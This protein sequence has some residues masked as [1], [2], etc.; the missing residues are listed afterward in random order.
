[1]AV[2]QRSSRSRSAER[3]FRGYRL[4]LLYTLWRCLTGPSDGAIRLEGFEDL[5]VLG[6]D[7]VIVEAVQVKAYNTPLVLSD[8][9]DEQTGPT[10]LRDRIAAVRASS[11]DARIKITSY[12]GFGPELAAFDKG[13]AKARRRV[14]AKVRLGTG[15]ELA[16]VI[17]LEECDENTIAASV[18]EQVATGIAGADVTTSTELMLY[19]LFQRAEARATITRAL[20]LERLEQVGRFVS[21]RAAHAAEW[22]TSIRPLTRGLEHASL[23]AL[24][25]QFDNGVNV[26]FEHVVAG[27]DVLRP[28]K[29][30]AVVDG[31]K[32]GSVV[33]VHGASG[34]GK[35]CL[36]YRFMHDHV[37]DAL[38]YEIRRVA[39]LPQAQR[40][41]L[42]LSEHARQC[43]TPVYVYVDVQPGDAQWSTLVEE[44]AVVP[45]LR[46]L[47]GIREEDWR[48]GRP[49]GASTVFEDLALAFDEIEARTLFD[50][51]LDRGQRAFVDFEDA[52]RNFGGAG[53][54]LEFTYLLTH[55]DTL[56]A[57]LAQQVATLRAEL[58]SNELT[59]LAAI[60]A[61]SEFGCALSVRRAS[62]AAN[63][64]RPLATLERLE[65]EY[66]VRVTDDPE[67][68]EGLHAVRSQIALDLVCDGAFVTWAAAAELALGALPEDAIE[69]FLFQGLVRRKGAAEV[70][71]GASRM[72]HAS[73]TGVAG[74]MRALLWRSI[75]DHVAGCAALI[76]E[77]RVTVPGAW[78]YMFFGNVIGLPDRGKNPFLDFIAKLSPETVPKV[79]DLKARLPRVNLDAVK[80]YVRSRQAGINPAQTINDW[81]GLAEFLFWTRFWEVGEVDDLVA[82][83][84]IDAAAALPLPVVL[85]L[86]RA[87]EDST[88]N[89]VV[90]LRARVEK[91]FR[92][93]FEV[94][95]IERSE[96]L[97]RSDF[98]VRNTAGVKVGTEAH[99]EALFQV[100]ALRCMYPRAETYGC[101]SHGALSF[102]DHDDTCKTGIPRDE[103]HARWAVHC[104]R[105]A[106]NLADYDER[107][108]TWAD[109][110]EQCASKRRTAIEGLERVAALLDEHFATL[111]IFTDGSFLDDLARYNP[112]LRANA[113]LPVS[114]VDPWGFATEGDRLD[115]SNTRALGVSVRAGDVVLAAAVDP[116]A[117]AM[118]SGG[119]RIAHNRFLGT[120]PQAP[121][122]Y[123]QHVRKVDSYLMSI[124]SF[125]DVA[126]AAV[127]YGNRTTR[128]PQKL[129]NAARRMLDA[130]N[131]ELARTRSSHLVS[132]LAAMQQSLRD[133]FGPRIETPEFVA[134]R[135]SEQRAVKRVWTLVQ[136]FC[137]DT[138]NK[139]QRASEVAEQRL[140][141]WLA[142][143]LNGLTEALALPP[144]A[145]VRAVLRNKPDELAAD[146]WIFVDAEDRHAFESLSDTIDNAIE[147]KLRDRS[148][149][150][151]AVYSE[152]LKELWVV[153]VFFGRTVSGI[154]VKS[155]ALPLCIE[156]PLSW[157]PVQID[158]EA[159]TAAGIQLIVNDAMTNLEAC[160]A[161][162][163]RLRALFERM[164]G[165]ASAPC[166]EYGAVVRAAVLARL[167]GEWARAVDD[168]IGATTSASREVVASGCDSLAGVPS[169][170]ALLSD[171][172]STEDDLRASAAI[173]DHPASVGAAD[174]L[175]TQLAGLV[176]HLSNLYFDLVVGCA[177]AASQT[178][179][180][181][182]PH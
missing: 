78:K 49:V 145:K 48:R 34:Q 32:K 92:D 181:V 88:A 107:P 100:E 117:F 67:R 58:S 80:S 118:G 123:G 131:V 24:Q 163:A 103:F 30:Q 65:R 75:R 71:T 120:V 69:T 53:P 74:V 115:S 133:D 110:F 76:A 17:E 87:L 164:L 9:Q 96:R 149:L 47:V 84:D 77:A 177:R 22:F 16:D 29:V 11:P 141:A 93:E 156:G 39:D 154:A 162:W 51:Y 35:S 70:L 138:A 52:W 180:R 147:N 109:H 73:W 122:V 33:I 158:G 174:E 128:G 23:D 151:R 166:D 20:V 146:L 86:L 99:D 60:L 15:V 172:A 126:G 57:R 114:A 173:L 25:L 7:G 85:S 132:E 101:A 40:I 8:V 4:Q 95:Q 5:D 129:R 169:L 63:L 31:F 124:T 167:K 81:I 12:S 94:L 3:T 116:L 18:F 26:R 142:A 157:W 130:K 140:N 72:S 143:K 89:A 106:R 91:R 6:G 79:E 41:V 46:I 45:Q 90:E 137:D 112:L 27:L 178:V 56:H 68:V 105:I 176:N 61:A 153:P 43:K 168:A 175:A 148:E 171:F 50:R 62:D 1:V 2:T 59:F 104:N 182:S 82:A 13:D 38:G 127:A 155:S 55:H 64:D 66:L 28:E 97:V 19:W 134:L 144:P 161:A 139:I 159:L 150:A 136:L 102:G 119:R 111:R 179:Q 108:Q 152:F 135:A 14:S 10:S 160:V 170:S 21:G 165:V 98:V 42:A 125:L 54:L 113:A 121:W 44:L 37:P 83:L 36:A